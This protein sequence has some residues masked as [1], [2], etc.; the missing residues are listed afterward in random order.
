MILTTGN[1]YFVH[2]GCVHVHSCVRAC[3]HV[4]SSVRACVYV[5]GLWMFTSRCRQQGWHRR[6]ALGLWTI[7]QPGLPW[8]QHPSLHSRIYD[9]LKQTCHNVSPCDV[10]HVTESQ[11]PTCYNV[12]HVIVSCR[13]C[14]HVWCVIMSQPPM[15]HGATM[16]DMSSCHNTWHVIMS[17]CLACHHIMSDMSSLL[18]MCH[19]VK[20]PTCHRVTIPDMSSFH[21]VRWVIMSHPTRHSVTN[22]AV[23]I[24]YSVW[25]QQ[26]MTCH[27]VTMSVCHKIYPLGQLSQNV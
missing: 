13:T 15:Y 21:N 7:S 3:V 8:L 5:Q 19:D 12:G 2:C 27:H 14:H 25:H 17:P 16:S 4:H 9:S 18:P 10:W 23:S 6:V 22:Y 26:N 20:C 11:C 1:T 24:C